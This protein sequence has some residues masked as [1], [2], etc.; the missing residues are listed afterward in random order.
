MKRTNVKLIMANFIVIS[1]LILN[2]NSFAQPAPQQP[3]PQTNPKTTRIN[4]H[5]RKCPKDDPSCK[6][7]KNKVKE[8]MKDWLATNMTKPTGDWSSIGISP[9][10]AAIISGNVEEEIL[11]NTVP[12]PDVYVQSNDG[13]G[14]GCT[15]LQGIYSFNVYQGYRTLIYDVQGY[16]T[17]TQAQNVPPVNFPLVIFQQTDEANPN[18]EIKGKVTNRTTGAPVSN[19]DVQL[20]K[21]ECGSPDSLNKT[22]KT[23]NGDYSFGQIPQGEYYVKCVC[24]GS[25]PPQ[26]SSITIPFT[27]SPQPHYDFTCN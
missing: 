17:Q 2:N 5:V 8:K 16:Q 20:Y 26:S 25:N 10:Y 27:S 18:Y 4:I 14:C 12:F 3:V 24:A 15:N 1:L 19:I 21:T 6:Q 7:L 9:A 22:V 23:C 13:S 11:T